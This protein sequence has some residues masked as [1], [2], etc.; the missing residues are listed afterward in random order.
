MAI[1]HCFGCTGYFDFNRAAKARSFLG[2]GHILNSIPTY[3]LHEA[4]P[5]NAGEHSTDCLGPQ[6]LIRRALA[7]VAADWTGKGPVAKCHSCGRDHRRIVTG[8]SA[9]PSGVSVRAEVG[10][11]PQND[12]P[13]PSRRDRHRGWDGLARV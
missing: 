9:F 6:R 8:V 5:L 11:R 13:H 2:I 7:V 10:A 12:V 4:G 1:T 3:G